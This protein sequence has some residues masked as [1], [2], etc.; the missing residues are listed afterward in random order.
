[1]FFGTTGFEALQD[2]LDITGHPFSS[3]TLTIN[4]PSWDTGIIRPISMFS[5]LGQYGTFGQ[6]V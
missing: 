1:M 3:V 5:F 4:C 6:Q 2:T